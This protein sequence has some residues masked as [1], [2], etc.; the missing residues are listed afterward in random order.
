MSAVENNALPGFSKLGGK[1]HLV[2]P[3]AVMGLLLVMMLPMPPLVMLFSFEPPYPTS[4]RFGRS[5]WIPS[6]DVARH[7]PPASFPQHR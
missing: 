3:I 2:I 6:S 5:Q 1:V 4:P 7:G